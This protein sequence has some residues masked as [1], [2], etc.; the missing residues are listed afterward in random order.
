MPSNE[1]EALLN[2][3][4]ILRVPSFSMP[5]GLLD[6]SAYLRQNVPDVHIELLDI[7]KDLYQFYQKIQNAAPLSLKAFI[8]L[9]LS[10]I[11]VAPDIVGISI[12]FSSAHKNSLLIADAVRQ[13]WGNAII[14]CG[15]NHAT[16]YYRNLLS[17][18]SIDYVIRGEGELSFAAFVKAVQDNIKDPNIQGLAGK[19]DIDGPSHLSPMVQVLD[20][21]PMPA[22][23]LLDI[24]FYRSTVGG[25]LMF[26]RG[27]PFHC[28]F[29]A[30]HTVHGRALRNK[31]NERI[32]KEFHRLIQG[33]R[34]DKIVIEDDAFAVKKENF[35]ALA[36]HLSTLYSSIKFFLPQGLSVA[37]M[38]ED[39]IDAMI[40]MGIDEASLAIE[41]GS[42][43]VQKHI[44]KKNVSLSKARTVLEYLRSKDFNIYINIILGFPGETRQLMQ[45]TINFMQTLDVDWVY[46]FHALPLPGSE[47]YQEFVAR[48]T[49]DPNDYDWDGVR[50]GRRNFDT[51]EISAE[52][53]ENL[54]YDTNIN[55]N[56][57]NNSNLKHGRYQRAIDIFNRIIIDQYP[58]H[59]VGR[60]CR[61]DAYLR[62]GRQDAAVADFEACRK[63]TLSNDESKRLYRRYH[64]KM[65]LLSP[66]ISSVD[67]RDGKENQ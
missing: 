26:T 38:D 61:G 54:V 64:E 5:I 45:E 9:E 36:S 2:K 42:P 40:S 41:S 58:F 32:M 47:L 66:Y 46:I 23:D 11:D 17:N 34:F 31:S 18:K 3:S 52:G 4:S 53:L 6:I 25:S 7:G 65:P 60:Y 49:I 15:G 16:N 20:D 12:L 8:D 37:L 10:T 13:K 21:I 43:Y 29:C 57:F 56:F 59:I 62:M 19:G 44:I 39:V 67:I 22:L 50:L 24:G 14:V 63:W 28:T 27:C 55:V 1:Q 48:G 33:L 30:S 35:L 51:P